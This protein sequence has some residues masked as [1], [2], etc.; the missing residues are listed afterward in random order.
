LYSKKRR[1]TVFDVLLSDIALPDGRGTEL[2]DSLQT[3]SKKPIRAIAMSGSGTSDDIKN[4]RL[5]GFAEHLTK[6][7]EP[8]AIARFA[9]PI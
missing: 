8:Q 6:P 2:L 9:A 1:L 7:I 4:S 3:H 5:A